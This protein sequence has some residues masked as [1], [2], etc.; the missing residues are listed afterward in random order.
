M[1]SSW[2]SRPVPWK[3]FLAK[4][5]ME[6]AE[7]QTAAEHHERQTGSPFKLRG[8][9][10]SNGPGSATSFAK[11]TGSNCWRDRHLQLVLLHHPRLPGARIFGRSLPRSENQKFLACKIYN[12]TYYDD[13]TSR[14]LKRLAEQQFQPY[15]NAYSS[16]NSPSQCNRLYI[17][18][19]HSETH[20]M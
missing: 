9:S 12:L 16:R 5:M 11:S 8:A 10:L 7:Y 1:G 18:W 2:V 4:R 14:L 6:Q 20:I 17:Y 3:H 15:A 19:H 13:K